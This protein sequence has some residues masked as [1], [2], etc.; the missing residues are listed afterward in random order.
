M[1]DGD[2]AILVVQRSA[3]MAF[4]AGAIVFPGGRIDQADRDL[5]ESVDDAAKVTA[6]RETIEES[7]VIAGLSGAITPALGLV[8]QQALIGGASFGPLLADH[9]LSLDPAA[10][11]PLARWRP[12]F[13]HARRFDTIF[14][15][16]RAAEGDWPPNPQPGECIAA[17]WASPADLLGRIASGA[18]SAI[19]PT[20]RNLE[21]LAQHQ[22]FEAALAD[23][24]AHSLETIVPWLA[25]IDGEQQICIPKGRGYP[26]TSEPL[27]SATRA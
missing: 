11:T 25:E 12:A 16:A 24:R 2:P 27:S 21:R 3:K 20:M 9:R 15:L 5:A 10:L 7:A 6:I 17:E 23:A 22:T 1:V 18:L 8:L 14:Y 4:A 13:L 26:I 19:F